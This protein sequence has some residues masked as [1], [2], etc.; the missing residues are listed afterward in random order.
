MHR[1]EVNRIIRAADAFMSRHGVHLPPFARWTPEEMRSPKA[2]AI[3][4]RG[5]GWDVTDYGQ[6]RFDDL[7]LFLFTTRN[8]LLSDL[9]ASR[10]EVYA[11]KIMISRRDQLSPMH[12]HVVKTEDI[13]NAGGGDL[14]LE[15]F[16]CAT[17]GSL[18]RDRPVRV[19][20]DGVLVELAPGAHLRLSP[21]QSVT[22]RPDT[23]HA[24]WA[25]GGDCLIREVST[26][27]DDRTDNIFADEI[28][29]FSDVK[30]DE[31]PLHL[32]VSDYAV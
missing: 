4:A 2:Q 27:N 26:V 5:L 10:G 23:W 15:L 3:R 32:L 1:S 22:L 25:E 28:G 24:F 13:I 21:G 18:D 9:D 29:R 31:A 19:P 11:E 6:G 30:E 17:D 7:G 20:S 14:V 12:R 8:G 16:A